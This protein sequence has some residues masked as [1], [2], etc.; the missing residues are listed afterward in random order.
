MYQIDKNIP[1]PLRQK[2]GGVAQLYPF[3]DMSV[4]DSFLV[5]CKEKEAKSKR[6]SVL[7]STKRVPLM[8]FTTRITSKGVRIWRIK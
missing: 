2:G 6:A 1:I 5:P 4:G 3:N 7:V 8:D